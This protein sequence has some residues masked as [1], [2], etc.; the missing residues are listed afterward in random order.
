MK[1][2]T[3]RLSALQWVGPALV[4]L[5][6][7]A[8]A[9]TQPPLFG[10]WP[11]SG[12]GASLPL[13]P[14]YYDYLT[15]LVF[16]PFL[17]AIGAVLV[18]AFR[19]LAAAPHRQEFHALMALGA[20]RRGLRSHQLRMGAIHGAIFS[21]GAT[22]L[23]AAFRQITAGGVGEF[24]SSTAWL[25]LT[26]AGIGVVT[27][28]VAYV[29][30]ARWVTDGAERSSLNSRTPATEVRPEGER[31]TKRRVLQ[32]RWPWLAIAILIASPLANRLWEASGY[33]YSGGSE[34]PWWARLLVGAA[35]TLG[36]ATWLATPALVM[37][38]GARAASVLGKLSGRA[39][40][41]G[42]HGTGFRAIAADGLLR[43][44]PVRRVA[45]VAIGT[46]MA[47]ATAL[48]I[49]SNSF[50]TCSHIAA[51]L[52]P[53][54]I[55]STFPMAPP[56]LTPPR[57]S[58]TAEGTPQALP[59]ALLT[60][61]TSDTRL[62]V[63]PSAVLVAEPNSDH[64]S[65]WLILAPDE[66]AFDAVSPG[67]ARTLYFSGARSW[68]HVYSAV[69]A[70]HALHV[71]TP[72][73]GPVT[74]I[75]R[76]WAEAQVGSRPTSAVLLYPSSDADVREVL[77]DYNLGGL[78]VTYPTRYP[79]S[80][81]SVRA[82]ALF[83]IAGPFLLIAIALVVALAFTVQRLRA[84]DYATMSAL[85]AT[86]SALRR[87]TAVESA[88]TTLIGS[89]LGLAVG[90]GFGAYLTWGNAGGD[91]AAVFDTTTWWNISFDIVHAPWLML[92]ALTVVATG[93]AAV[94][95]VFA[96]SRLDASSPSEQLREAVKEGAL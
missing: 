11:D 75:P 40:A 60:A 15:T 52:A 93:L 70:G 24:N 44:T 5:V 22:V 10:Y 84:G 77:A 56:S 28:L 7:L 47:I 30:V 14:G 80:D 51:E 83:G 53:H 66:R 82:S 62:V 85:G 29:I 35:V 79:A 55:V 54:A 25:L 92:G 95:S 26:T 34:R 39:L 68:G 96:R 59:D 1:D 72:S 74:G 65:S 43:H 69:V 64:P 16:S 2:T 36:F 73:P 71:P 18:G 81:N 19:A 6:A 37:L 76:T 89:I 50:D 12:F 91:R 63:V 78:E 38:V 9:V 33:Q 90:A 87:A 86:Q 27:M 88:V 41:A 67:A 23:G 49:Q 46:V 58:D 8:V 48:S 94:G 42:S 20:S 57:A 45:T 31:P 3:P 4:G 61:L 13:L 17:V 32:W 21:V